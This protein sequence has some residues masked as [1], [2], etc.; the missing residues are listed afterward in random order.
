MVQLCPGA[1]VSE[2]KP[3]EAAVANDDPSSSDS[4][5]DDDDDDED[6][7]SSSSDATGET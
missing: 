3:P 4:D 5:S 2:E 1:Q 7:D 6:S